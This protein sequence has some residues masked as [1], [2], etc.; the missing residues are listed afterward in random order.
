LIQLAW[1]VDTDMWSK[2]ATNSIDAY[3]LTIKEH[4]RY[5][6][7][8]NYLNIV[9][10]NLHLLGYYYGSTNK[11]A[12]KDGMDNVNNIINLIDSY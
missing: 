10:E 9:Y 7:L 2:K 12:I 3:L 1:L 11:N 4:P 5:K 8:N 6:V